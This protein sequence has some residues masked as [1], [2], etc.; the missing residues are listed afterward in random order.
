MSAS[1]VQDVV[2]DAFPMLQMHSN[3]ADTRS[4]IM[5]TDNPKRMG[6]GKSNYLIINPRAEY[7]FEDF[8]M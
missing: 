4:W 8:K 6:A 7:L 2:L 5:L 1:E 3:P